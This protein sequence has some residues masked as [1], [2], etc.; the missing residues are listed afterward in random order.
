M[1]ALQFV[2]DEW[3]EKDENEEFKYVH[4]ITKEGDL[5]QDKYIVIHENIST[6][7]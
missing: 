7:L 2:P 1:W 3:I 4:A 6:Q 5:H